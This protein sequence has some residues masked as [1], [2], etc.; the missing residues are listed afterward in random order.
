MCPGIF[1]MYKAYSGEKYKLP[2]TYIG[3]W[4]ENFR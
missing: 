1:L 2:Y 4:A 3:E